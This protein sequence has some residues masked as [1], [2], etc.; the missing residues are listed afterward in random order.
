VLINILQVNL[1]G[2]EV[3]WENLLNQQMCYKITQLQ[4]GFREISMATHVGPVIITI[5][6]EEL[7]MIPKDHV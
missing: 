1:K 2:V 7:I 6:F 5:C 3:D 4:K